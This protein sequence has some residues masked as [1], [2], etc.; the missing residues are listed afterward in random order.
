M[1]SYA[2]LLLVAFATDVS[3]HSYSY[4]DPGTFD[5]YID[6]CGCP[7]AFLKDWCSAD[8]AM[9]TAPWCGESASNCETCT[10]TACYE[11]SHLP[12]STT[13]AVVSEPKEC[14]INQCGCPGSFL[15]SWCS[16]HSAKIT[17]PWCNESEDHCGMC[18]GSYCADNNDS[19]PP[20]PPPAPTGECFISQC[21]CPGNF[22]Q[23]WCT[24]ASAKITSPWCN[25]N[26]SNC[27]TCSGTYCPILVE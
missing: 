5:C 27:G 9:I 19:T 21:G 7:G 23:E 20:T 17:S 25:D 1:K 13:P 6:E 26:D 3:A 2:A 15:Y 12:V 11:H 4:E 10:G 16:E 8:T 22:A 18:S 14:Y 24:E